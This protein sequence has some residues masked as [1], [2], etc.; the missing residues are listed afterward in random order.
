LTGALLIGLGTGAVRTADVVDYGPIGE[1]LR[2]IS[3]HS[4]L[5]KV[6]DSPNACV[7]GALRVSGWANSRR[8]T[9][10]RTPHTFAIVRALIDVMR[11][12]YLSTVALET[13]ETELSSVL[14]HAFIL[15]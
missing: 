15:T 10:E 12:K 2:A 1:G 8:G 6:V 9:F 13:E 11:P 4:A 5:T 14:G 3:E 7:I